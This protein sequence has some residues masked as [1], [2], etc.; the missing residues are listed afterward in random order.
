MVTYLRN[1]GAPTVLF[2]ERPPASQQFPDR[3]AMLSSN[4]ALLTVDCELPFSPNSNHSR[5]PRAPFA[6]GSYAKTGGGSIIDV[7]MYLKYIGA[8]IVS[9]WESTT[10]I[11]PEPVPFS[12]FVFRVSHFGI[13]L[14]LAPSRC[15]FSISFFEFRCSILLCYLAVHSLA[16]SVS[17]EGSLPRKHRK[18]FMERHFK[19]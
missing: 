8:P 9:F 17:C 11:R 5:L 15:R 2:R 1:A 10:A 7:V 3:R 6:K 4:C 16:P 12:N 19:P 14:S 18:F 13:L